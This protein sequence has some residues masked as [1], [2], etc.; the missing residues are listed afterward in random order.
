[1]N[2]HAV[3]KWLRS[4]LIAALLLPVVAPSVAGSADA[5]ARPPVL[6]TGALV[7]ALARHAQNDAPVVV[8]QGIALLLLTRDMDGGA[9]VKEALAGRAA[10][11]LKNARAVYV[12]DVSGMPSFVHG[13]FALPALRKRAYPVA[14]DTEGAV[15]A[16]LPHQP[17]KATVLRLESGRV[18]S[19]S[20]VSTSAEVAAALGL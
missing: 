15:T 10:D 4:L 3:P 2:R 7:P 8:D 19:V 13:A 20:F 18:A 1:M 11:V 16:A 14:L 5:V 6:A 17:G 9:L 12:S